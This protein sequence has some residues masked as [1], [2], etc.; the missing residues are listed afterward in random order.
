[1]FPLHGKQSVTNGLQ[2]SHL[3]RHWLVTLGH[4]QNLQSS[5][6]HLQNNATDFKEKLLGVILFF[7]KYNILKIH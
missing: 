4:T 5:V 2:G 1:M 3:K 7:T 6:Q